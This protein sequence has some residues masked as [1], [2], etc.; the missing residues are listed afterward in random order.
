VIDVQVRR[1]LLHGKA[2]VIDGKEALIAT[3]NVNEAGFSCPGEVCVVDRRL[4]DVARI[5]KAVRGR[6]KAGRAAPHGARSR[7]LTGPERATRLRIQGLLR[8]R[9]D[10]SIAVED[11][12]DRAVVQTLA[13]RA[14]DRHHDRVLVN[15]KGGMSRSGKCALGELVAAHVD[16]RVMTADYMHDKYIDG[17]DQIFIGSQNLTRNG[18]EEAR[19]V[20]ILAPVSD[21]GRA[22]AALRRDFERMWRS[23]GHG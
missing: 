5:S 23:A 17:G 3:G 7:V 8:S 10:V 16:A 15:G 13:A 1:S 22:A 2:A 18:L 9:A 11:L 19:E 20:G 12:S 6:D 14:K 21:F 4:T